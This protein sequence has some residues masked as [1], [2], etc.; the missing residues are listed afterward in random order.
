MIKFILALLEALPILDKWF[1]QALI[2]Y[3]NQ[4]REKNN[5]E[6]LDAMENAKSK[7][8]ISDLARS[9]GDKLN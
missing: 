1:Q 2:A 7:K 8:D 9:I 5:V 6:F 4:Q 3:A